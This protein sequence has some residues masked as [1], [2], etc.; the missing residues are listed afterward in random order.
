MAA[1]TAPLSSTLAPASAPSPHQGP[2]KHSASVVRSGYLSVKEDGLRSWIW[3][4]KWLV[5]R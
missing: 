5:L 1:F 3:S 2:F 4:K